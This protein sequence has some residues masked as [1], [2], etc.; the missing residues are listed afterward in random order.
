MEEAI[1]EAYT[2]CPSGELALDTLEV[3][4]PV[5]GS[6]KYLVSDYTDHTFRLEDGRDQLFTACGFRMQ[7]PAAGDNGVQQLDIAMDDINQ[8]LSDFLTA[9]KEARKEIPLIYRPYLLSDPTTSQ[10]NPPLRLFLKDVSV[11]PQQVQGAASFMD[12]INKKFPTE[13]YTRARFPSLAGG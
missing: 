10:L 1:K 2:V 6:S 11:T 7:L 9:A 13:I 8:E 12:I 5:D 3:I 4:N